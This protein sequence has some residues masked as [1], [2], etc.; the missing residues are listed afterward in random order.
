MKKVLGGFGCLGL[1]A[2]LL[3]SV[4]AQAATV[5]A[6]RRVATPEYNA[7][8]EITLEGNVT[9]VKGSVPG[10]LAGGHMFVATSRGTIDGHLGPYALRGTHRISVATGAHVT[11]VGVMT[12]VK[13]SQVFL[14][15]TVNT[16]AKTYT[17]RN[18]HGFPIL[19]S[20]TQPTKQLTALTGGRR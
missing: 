5:V 18:I 6:P 15:R 17:I 10:R 9:S 3:A 1:L 12:T 19:L 4:S 11:L 8:K 7:S 20:A 13:G 2:F 14:V 16:G